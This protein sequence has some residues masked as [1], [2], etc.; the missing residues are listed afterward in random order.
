MPLRSRTLLLALVPVIFGCAYTN[1]KNDMLSAQQEM[2]QQQQVWKEKQQT[3]MQSLVDNQQSLSEQMLFLQSQMAELRL[4]LVSLKTNYNQTAKAKQEPVPSVKK[5][6]MYDETKIVLGRVEWIWLDI[7]TNHYKAR[8]DTGAATSTLVARDIQAFERDGEDWVRFTLASEQEKAQLEAP[9]L[10]YIKI[11]QASNGIDRRPVVKVVVRFGDVSEEI[12]FQLSERDNSVYPVLIG[13][14]FLRD[15][16]V[17][18][19]SK[20]FTQPKVQVEMLRP[21]LGSR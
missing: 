9:L 3:Q 1:N 18:D 21:A 12:E 4:G 6:L 10:R 16:A 13:R 17:V 19:V 11:R 15:I 5:I 8:I 7:A 14:N 2:H 20:K